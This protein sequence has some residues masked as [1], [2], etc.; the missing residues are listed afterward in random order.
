M[1]NHVILFALILFATALVT[2]ASAIDPSMP[3]PL[4]KDAEQKRINKDVQFKENG[5]LKI[6]SEEYEIQTEK[7]F[8]ER[9][10]KSG[11]KNFPK[12]KNPDDISGRYLWVNVQFLKPCD[13]TT[14]KEESN[15][16]NKW[17]TDFLDGKSTSTSYQPMPM[18]PM[19]HYKCDYR[20]KL[21]ITFF[22]AN[23]TEIKTEG[24]FINARGEEGT[25]KYKMSIFPGEKT[26]G[27]FSVPDNTVYYYT[28]VPK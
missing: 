9:A 27:M 1:K 3:I 21:F 15:K 6:L 5:W 7:D 10:L 14:D 22:N 2:S 17:W 20:L 11:Q 25:N 8:Y 12:P 16:W 13:A 19:P 23:G 4:P 26:Y 28:W 24:E 18:I